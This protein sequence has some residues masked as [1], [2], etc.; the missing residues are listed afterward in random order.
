MVCAIHC[1]FL[2]VILTMSALGGLQWMADP[3]IELSFLTLSVGIAVLALMKNARKHKHIRLAI[4]TIAIGFCLV[5]ASRFVHPENLH[6]GLTALGGIVIASGHIL[7]WRL[8]KSS[9]CCV[10]H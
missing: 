3:V 5:I 7:N 9:E 1:A 4:Q 8:A 2:P 10:E 6:H